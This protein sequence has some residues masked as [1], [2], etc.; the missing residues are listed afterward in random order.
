MSNLKKLET[1][2]KTS[3][4]KKDLETFN[5]ALLINDSVNLVPAQ[6]ITTMVTALFRA[7]TAGGWKVAL[8][9]NEALDESMKVSEKLMTQFYR[10][11]ARDMSWNSTPEHLKEEWWEIIGADVA[12]KIAQ[13][14]GD[15]TIRNTFLSSSP[16]GITMD[17]GGMMVTERYNPDTGEYQI[18]EKKTYTRILNIFYE[19]GKI[20]TISKDLG[21]KKGSSNITLDQ[22]ASS[23]IEGLFQVYNFIH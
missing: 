10:P 6:D 20:E 19:N 8:S 15:K 14:R 9:F 17:W 4:K 23:V 1:L 12:A 11:L 18:V 21:L 13:K 2:F 16:E 3:I 5:Q 22:T 7:K